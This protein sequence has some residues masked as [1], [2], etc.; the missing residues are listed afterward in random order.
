MSDLD[1]LRSLGEQIVPPPFEELRATAQRRT[2]RTATAST[3]VVGVAVALALGAVQ[4]GVTHRDNP[5]PTK[6]DEQYGARPLT[7]AEGTSLHFGDRVIPLSS[8]VVEIDLA[9]GGVTARTR[10]GAI[11]LTN[12]SE[13]EQVGTLGEPGS[14]F[15]PTGLNQGAAAGFVVSGNSGSLVAWWEFPAP[16]RPELVVYDTAARREN[17]RQ[18]IQL[19]A[20]S[21]ALLASV[22][23]RYAYW[24]VDP[25]DVLLDPPQVRVDLATGEQSMVT[26]KGYAADSP[27][28]GTART[29]LV[30][31]QERDTPD[32]VVEGILA[33]LQQVG[34]DGPRGGDKAIV[35]IGPDLAEVL[36]GA[37]GKPFAFAPPPGYRDPDPIPGWLTQWID[38]DTVVVAFQGEK[39]SDLLECRLSTAECELAVRSVEAVLPEIG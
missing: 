31:H 35:P 6:Q 19:P 3:V 15:E 37:T 23:D 5:P 11:W 25:E 7:Y 38:D 18:P 14:G 2:R 24:Y 22:D 12:G 32:Q 16:G 21:T 30:R 28:Q 29:L 1:L 39:S 4:L 8:Q 10:D 36:D 13:P 9:D 26:S 27:P 33:G 34:F 20:G 17:L